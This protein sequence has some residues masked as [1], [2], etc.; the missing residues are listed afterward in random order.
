[1]ERNG[2]ENWN[3]N[4]SK[5]GDFLRIK[6]EDLGDIE[7]T[8][9]HGEKEQVSCESFEKVTKIEITRKGNIIKSEE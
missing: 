5:V 2:R 8:I 4:V 1:M 3:L 9:V 7:V 6:L